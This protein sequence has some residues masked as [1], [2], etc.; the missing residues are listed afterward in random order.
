MNNPK[1]DTH[2]LIPI[3]EYMEIKSLKENL[4]KKG[5]LVTIHTKG[6]V[7]YSWEQYYRIHS[8]NVKEKD[9]IKEMATQIQQLE[10]ERESWSQRYDIEMSVLKKMSWWDF[11]KW[12]KE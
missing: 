11:L 10:D 12:K 3:D 7:I 4:D 6:G 5:V 1:P 8:R 2:V 9:L